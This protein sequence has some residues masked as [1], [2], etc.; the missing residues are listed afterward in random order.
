[1]LAP[2]SVELIVPCCSYQT[3]VA[4]KN[5]AGFYFIEHELPDVRPMPY[6]CHSEEKDWV[7]WQ[8][9]DA[10]E[11]CLSEKEDGMN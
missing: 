1:M 2:V 3:Y 11:T 6:T 9:P 4:N 8:V 10:H 7:S 5:M